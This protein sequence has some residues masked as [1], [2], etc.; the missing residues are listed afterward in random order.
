MIRKS[1]FVISAL[2]LLAGVP[3]FSANNSKIRVVA[4]FNAMKEFTEAVGKEFVT[5]DTIIPNGTEPHEFE[6]KASDLK[7]LN[8]AA[9]FVYNGAGMEL[10]VAK[11]LK[12][13]HNKKLVTVEASDGFA[14][15]ENTSEDEIREHGK[16]DPHV[17]LSLKGAIHEA[18]AIKN[19]LIAVDPAHKSQYEKNYNEF[20]MQISLLLNEYKTKFENIGNKDF[21]T[22]HAA[23]GYL[24]RDFGLTQNSVEDVFAEGEPGPRKLAE[25]VEYC[26]KNKVTTIF[27]E[28]LVSPKISETLAKEVGAKTEKIYTLESKEDGKDYLA[29]MRDNLAKIYASLQ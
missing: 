18:N 26:K 4:S 20:A 27:T 16:Y 7:R 8:N 21:V 15:I 3:G 6:P 29:S 12:A 1:F 13:V 2:M 17:W 14:L 11:T 24:C 25:L 28:D 23:F 19:A 9:I 5:V 22:G 10:W